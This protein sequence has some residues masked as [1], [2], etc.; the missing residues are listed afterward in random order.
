MSV[1]WRTCR[2]VKN[3]ASSIR[4]QATG[5]RSCSAFTCAN[6][7]ALSARAIAGAASPMRDWIRPTPARLSIIG[8]NSS[9]RIPRS[10]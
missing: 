5:W 7:L 10:W 8:M 4:T 2:R 3:C 9:V 6:K 1:A